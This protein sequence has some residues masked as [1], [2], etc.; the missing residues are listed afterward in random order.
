VPPAAA[1]ADDDDEPP[2]HFVGV[3]ELRKLESDGAYVL[4]K[5]ISLIYIF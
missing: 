4:R 2:A 3:P 5:L 1:P